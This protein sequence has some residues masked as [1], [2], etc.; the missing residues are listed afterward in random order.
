MPKPRSRAAGLAEYLPL[1]GRIVF[2][3]INPG[4]RSAKVGHHYAGH[5]NRFWKL[6]YDSGLVPIPLTYQDDWRLPHWG[7]GL[8]NLI[9]RP[10]K[11]SQ[12]LDEDDYRDSQTKLIAKI[13]QVR[14]Q[15]VAILGVSL[16]AAILR[17]TQ[18]FLHEHK[19]SPTCR[20]TGLQEYTI[21]GVKVFVLPNP[22]GRNAHYSY[23]E[24]LNL[25]RQLKQ[26]VGRVTD[27]G[28]QDDRHG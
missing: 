28:C 13:R 25:F 21:A 14:P 8:T 22:S 20:R 11:G 19:K 17:Y 5:S 16:W 4:I 6:L 2:V 9:S 27:T 26:L 10:T 7:Y 23:A 12:D 3:G 1:N 18:P 24:M 15:I